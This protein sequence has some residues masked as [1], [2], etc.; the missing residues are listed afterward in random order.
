MYYQCPH[1]PAKPKAPEARLD[2]IVSLFFSKHVFGPGRKELLAAQLPATDAAAAADRDAQAAA[3]RSRIKKIDTAQ[4]S[5]ILELEQLPAD[6]ADTAAAAMRARIR[7]RFAQLHHDREQA[8]AQLA[9]LAKTTPKAA[10]PTLLDQL[11][12]AGDILPR[13]SP[14]LKAGLF[15][16]F[17][18]QVLWNKPGQ[19]AT[20]FA[21][22]TEAT[23]TA[24]PAILNPGQDGYHDTAAEDATQKPGAMEDLFEPSIVH[25]IDRR[26][27]IR[28]GTRRS[29]PRRGGRQ[30][31]AAICPR[32]R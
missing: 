25:R 13:L 24:L 31:R 6:P 18:L 7:D 30:R 23:L 3:L 10:D 2:Q 4:N 32:I 14:E 22:I 11:P 8:E 15:A 9:T 29:G 20:V 28:R 5:C 12:L 26:A 16:A 1:N 27:P 21:E 17:D 19:Q